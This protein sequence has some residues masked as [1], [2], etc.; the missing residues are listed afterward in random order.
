MA[1]RPEAPGEP[2]DVML[3]C[4]EKGQPYLTAGGKRI[5]NVTDLSTTSSV[6]DLTTINA[7]FV[8]RSRWVWCKPNSERKV[9]GGAQPQ[10]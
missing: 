5:R 1:D 7:T 8:V 2:V 9:D 6:R 3:A 10:E 4:D